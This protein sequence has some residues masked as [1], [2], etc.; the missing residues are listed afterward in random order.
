MSGLKSLLVSSALDIPHIPDIFITEYISFMATEFH[1]AAS[2]MGADTSDKLS[3][4]CKK[5]S[6]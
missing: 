4:H 2:D 3:I 1:L 6:L 5:R